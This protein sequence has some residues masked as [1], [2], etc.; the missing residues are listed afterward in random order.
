MRKK[1]KPKY[2]SRITGVRVWLANRLILAETS[3]IKARNN[4]NK[5]EAEYAF[6]TIEE[7]LSK[8]SMRSAHFRMKKLEED[9]K[10]R[11]LTKEE[12]EAREKTRS[13]FRARY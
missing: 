3:Y 7:I 6:G 2:V 9:M 10:K 4:K 5:A 1:L 12:W 8:P 11:N 13:K